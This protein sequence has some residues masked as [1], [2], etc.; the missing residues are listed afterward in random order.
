MNFQRV[1]TIATNGFRETI[2]DR[3]LYFLGF[4]ALLLGLALRLLP[5]ITA[6]ITSDKLVLDFGLA[7]ISVLSV[8]VA[9]FVGTGLI[10]KEIERRT[11]LVL[12]PKPISRA[13]FIVGKH[14]GLAAVLWVLL[15]C[16]AAI[17]FILLTLSGVT[18]PFL[19]MTVSMLYL[20]IELM[21]MVAVAL[22]FGVF[23]SSLLAALLSLGV[24]LM[25]H[26]SPDLVEL[27]ELSDNEGVKTLTQTLYLILPDL[28]QFN[29]KNDAVYG[30]VPPVAELASR[31]LY[32]G[33]YTTV[34]LAIAVFVFSRRQF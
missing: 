7:A 3:V 2:R 27:G 5:E 25:G 16:M 1:W 10:N 11:V 33:L 9:V 21:L 19:T 12:I 31:A 30:I 22:V 4:F 20:F 32:G 15:A 14:L 13:E 34:L 26:F 6:D 28:S 17:Y 23:T 18:Y 29:L 8:V 24:Y